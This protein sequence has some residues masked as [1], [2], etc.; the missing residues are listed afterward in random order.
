MTNFPAQHDFMFCDTLTPIAERI[1]AELAG[2]EPITTEPLPQETAE[3]LFEQRRLK[4][5]E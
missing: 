2:A 4:R 5:E 1:V 3:S